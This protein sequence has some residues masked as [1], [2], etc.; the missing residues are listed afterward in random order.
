MRDLLRKLDTM[1]DL[2]EIAFVPSFECFAISF[3][4]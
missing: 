1:H 2:P 4:L 3:L